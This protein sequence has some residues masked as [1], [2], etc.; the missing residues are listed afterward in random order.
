MVAIAPHPPA[1][2]DRPVHGA[3]EPDGEA[4]DPAHER[5]MAVRLAEEMH[6]VALHGVVH[7]AEAPARRCGERRAQRSEYVPVPETGDVVARAQGDVDRRPR[8]VRGP[9]AVGD[10]G[11]PRAGSPGAGSSAAVRARGGE[12][13]L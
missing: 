4:L 2:P 5:R 1:A 7:D 9:A 3:R 13:E 10:A 6:V 11:V 12:R 8:V